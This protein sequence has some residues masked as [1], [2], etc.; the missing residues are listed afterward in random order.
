MAT[1]VQLLR[2]SSAYKR[3]SPAPLLDGQVCM[4]F[5]A[6]EP[7]LFFRLTNGE[8]CKAGPAAITI[9][10]DP[11]NSAPA[12]ST[13]NCVGELWLNVSPY[14]NSPILHVFNG[15]EFVTANGFTVDKST[16]DMTCDRN[17]K[18]KSLQIA[19]AGANGNGDWSIQPDQGQLVAVDNTTGQR[20]S[21]N[22][23]A[24][25]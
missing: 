7:G 8:L 15:T 20:Y 13:G 21:I 14:Y 11:P 9:T 4:N 17:L 23:T 3:P 22:L 2:S 1:N 6:A 16:G 18:L 19:G 5:N 12:G 24:L 10:G 25:P